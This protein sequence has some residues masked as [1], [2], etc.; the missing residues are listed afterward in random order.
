MKRERKDIEE[1]RIEQLLARVGRHV[2]TPPERELRAMARAAAESGRLPATD[3][4]RRRPWRPFHLRWGVGVAVALLIGSG[5]GFGLGAR[6][7]SDGSAGTTFVGSGFLPAKGWT[8]VQ[9]GAVGSARAARAIAT[10]VSLHP[11]DKV[12]RMPYATLEALPPGG[13]LILATFTTRGDPGEDARFDAHTLPLRM[14]GAKTVS[15]RRDSLPFPRRLGQYRVRAAVGGYNVDARV[16]FGSAQPPTRV[17]S[18]AQ[19]Q[20]SRLVVSSERVTIAARPSILR[21]GQPVTVFGAVDN[22]RADELVRIQAKDCGQR[23]FRDVSSATTG[24]GGAWSAVVHLGISATLRAVWEET[25]STQVT[26][27]QRPVLVLR[28]EFGRRFQV[29][30][31]GKTSFWRK[32]VRVERLDRRLGGWATVKSVALG[33]SG[34]SPGDPYPSSEAE[35]TA[36]IPKGTLLRAVLPRSQARPCYLAGYSNLLRT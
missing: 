31:S 13:V 12:G 26:V 10:N 5:F 36:S 29:D 24:D 2:P 22:R 16:Y 11:D 1:R 25:A 3:V 23:F 28:R 35:F 6:S 15:P 7:T 8:V 30:V 32:R 17:V 33:D 34:A 27:Q 14:A 9:S 21:S 20:L 18:A 19:H 4:A